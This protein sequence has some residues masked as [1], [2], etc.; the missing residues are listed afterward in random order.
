MPKL[1]A[2]LAGLAT[3]AVEPTLDGAFKTVPK[4]AVRYAGKT[5]V[6]FVIPNVV[7]H[8]TIEKLTPQSYLFPL[9]PLWER[10]PLRHSSRTNS[11]RPC[12]IF[13]N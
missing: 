3:V 1:D 9:A 2:L 13:P 11:P 7:E 5:P 12:G 6:W 8:P 4:N 10:V